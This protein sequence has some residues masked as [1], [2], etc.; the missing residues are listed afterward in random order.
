MQELAL[1]VLHVYLDILKEQEAPVAMR[2]AKLAGV[3]G[4][5]HPK[6][7]ARIWMCQCISQV[8]R[9]TVRLEPTVALEGCFIIISDELD[10]MLP[11]LFGLRERCG[12][13][14]A[15]LFHETGDISMH[16]SEVIE[17]VM[18]LLTACLA[19]ACITAHSPIPLPSHCLNKCA[20]A[21]GFDMALGI[22][23]C[24]NVM[25]FPL[26]L[27]QRKAFGEG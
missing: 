7:A 20:I 17:I 1:K 27:E 15:M 2:T 3:R 14:Q 4:V 12:P 10:L 8:M 19:E 18:A 11:L 13:L 16:G 25:R 21:Y 24:Q 5:V 9:N 26:L 23:I 6:I 22:A